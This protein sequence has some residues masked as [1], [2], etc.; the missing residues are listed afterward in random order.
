M[1]ICLACNWRFEGGNWHC[2]KCKH[3]PHFQNAYPVFAPDLTQDDSFYPEHKYAKLF[4]IEA[5]NFWFK[6][7]N[8]LLI[9][10]LTRHYSN[11]E[12]FLEIGCG[13]G[14]VIAGIQQAFPKVTLS[15]SDVLTTGLT[16]AKQRL[17]NVSFFQMDARSIPFE[18]EFDL[19]GA[20]DVLEHIEE[21]ELVLSQMF[22]ATKSGGGIVLTVPQH[23]SLWSARDDYGHHKRR[24]T[25]AEL[26]SKVEG[27][28]FEILRT[29]SFVSLLLP[30]L[31]LSRRKQHQPEDNPAF[32]INLFL[33]TCLEKILDMERGFIRCGLSF[34]AG[35]SLL[36][37]A[38]HP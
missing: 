37:V 19:I 4:E 10:A 17:P 31:F 30:L 5:N 14:F 27:S 16:Y 29:T 3:S 36:L 34:P 22:Q 21:D 7:R 33:N 35:G 20:F 32:G 28:G 13:T 23:P 15:A 26:V 8:Q 2:P 11:I 9:W 18:A 6:S 24:Y 12:N 1:K 38:Q 25:R